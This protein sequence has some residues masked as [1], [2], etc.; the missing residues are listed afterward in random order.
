M[1]ISQ[2]IIFLLKYGPQILGLAKGIWDLVDWICLHDDKVSV[3][4]KMMS[5]NLHM[6]ART[7]KSLSDTSE[8]ERYRAA[9]QRRKTEISKETSERF[10]K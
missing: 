10:P 8:L 9:L 3:S 1:P 4:G 2:I 6:M 7:A 5:Q